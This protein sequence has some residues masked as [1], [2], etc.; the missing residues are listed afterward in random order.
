[1]DPPVLVARIENVAQVRGVAGAGTIC[2]AE[3]RPGLPDRPLPR[4][5]PPAPR[6]LHN[7]V[8]GPRCQW[9]QH[10]PRAHAAPRTGAVACLLLRRGD[11]MD[12][13]V[14]V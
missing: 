4:P 2:R 5:T 8:C 10:L 14:L 13:P 3:P 1:M 9:P 11:R 6:S 12:P 7:A